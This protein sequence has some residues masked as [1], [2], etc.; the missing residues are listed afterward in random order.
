VLDVTA[1]AAP[2]L[3]VP[4]EFPPPPPGVAPPLDELPAVGRSP[5]YNCGGRARLKSAIQSFSTKVSEQNR[6]RR[7][8]QT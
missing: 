2:P 6:K 7:F 1:I 3:F 4:F 8:T 5:V